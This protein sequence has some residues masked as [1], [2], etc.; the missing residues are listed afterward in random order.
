MPFLCPDDCPVCKQE[1]GIEL[2]W[3]NLGNNDCPK[4]GAVSVIEIDWDTEYYLEPI[5]D[6]DEG[7]T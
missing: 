1:H 2:C 5:D 7:K 3:D 4:C 6:E